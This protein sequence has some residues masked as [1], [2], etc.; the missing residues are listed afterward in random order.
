MKPDRMSAIRHHLFGHGFASVADIAR[1]LQVSEPTV[2]RDLTLMEAAGEVTRRH[3][4][5]Q[6]AQGSGA[7]VAF[8][9]REQIALAQKRAIG[10][11]AYQ[12]LQPDT[13]V[14]LDAGTTVL[15]LARRL[16]MNPLRLRVFTNCLAVA[17]M[18]MAAPGVAV[19]LLGGVVRMQNASVVGPMA[20]DALTRLWFD[21]VFLGVGGVSVA[22]EIW[23]AD[24]QE[25]RLNTAMLARTGQRIILADT[26][27][28]GRQ[29]TYLVGSVAGAQVVVDGTLGP[30]WGARLADWGCSVTRCP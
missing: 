19:T 27:K 26:G 28:F 20:E 8:E 17:Q 4:G 9:A 13:A 15:Q 1:A 3:G 16:R 12:M 10:V 11:A 29:L 6:I 14:F 2:R 23:S 24:E 21:Q 7:E 22:G 18:L 5:A 25:A 30:E